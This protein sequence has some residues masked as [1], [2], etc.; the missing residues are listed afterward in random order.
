MSRKH[1]PLKVITRIST[2][3]IRRFLAKTK[4]Q[5]IWLL[6]TIFRTQ[7]KQET[8]NAGFVLPTV[9]MVSIVVVLLTTAIMLRSFDRA[10][11]ASNVRVSQGAITSATPAIDRGRAKI[12]L[13]F[14]D[15]TLPRA[16]PT[17]SSLYNALANSIEKYTFG[18]ETALQISFDING[19]GTI[20]TPTASTS[21]YNNE[22]MKTAWKFPVDTD[23]NG[24]FDSYNIYGI[25]F[26]TPPV[27]GT[28]QYKQARNVLEA[29]TPPMA[30]GTVDANCDANSSA[31]LVGNSGWVKQSNKLK[32]SFFVY[33]ATVPIT[34]TST[35]TNYEIYKGNKGFAAV[36]YQQDRVQIPPNNTAVVYED[37]IALSPGANFNLNGSVFTNSNFITSSVNGGAIR[38]YQVS[39]T[40]SCYYDSKNAKIIVGGNTALGGFLS[41]TNT[42]SATVDL[43]NGKATAVGTG[44]WIQS[45]GSSPS[46]IA[47]NN[48]AYVNRI[49]K[50][51]NAQVAADS[52]GA[53][54]PIE[55]KNGLIAKQQSLGI[56][57]T[58]PSADF[59]KYRRQQL[60]FY[61]RKRTRRVPYTEV[62]FSSTDTDPTPLL[63]GS[64]DTLRPNDRWTYPTSPT[65]GK[66]D[67]TY[68]KV[69]LNIS[70][71]SLRPVAT[72]PT[73]LKNNSGIE[74][75]I[76]DRVLVGNNLPQ[77]WWD[78]SKSAFVGPNPT[79]TQ[80]I[81]GIRW[82][83]GD[84][85][86]TRTR[87]S[88]VQTL[89]DVGSIDRDGEWELAAA[90]VPADITEPVGGLRVVTGAGI[91]LNETGTPASFNNTI[92]TIW[93]DT[94]PVPQAGIQAP[95]SN[96]PILPSYSS[97]AKTIKPYSNYGDPF[98]NITYKWREIPN[99][100]TPFLQMRATAVYHYKSTSYNAQTPTPIA[101]VS[102]FHVPTNST[103]AK[104]KSTLPTASG[105]SSDTNG[106]SDNGIVYPAPNAG[107]VPD[108]STVLTYQSQL[109]YPNGR[110]I[111]DGLLARALAKTAANRTISEQSAIDAQICALRIRYDSTFTP[112]TTNPV[113]DHGAIRE[114][115]L[116]DAREVK[117]NSGGSGTSATSDDVILPTTTYDLPV[118]DR[119][120]VEIR[121]TV[122]DLN[123]LRTKTIGSSSPSQEYLLPNSGI[124]YA[125]RDDALRDMSADIT[126]FP[127]TSSNNIPTEANKSVS[128]VDYK[129]DPSRRPN[130]IM[131]VNGSKLWRGLR[132]ATTPPDY[133]N[134][135]KGLILAT[136]L[137][138]YLKGDFN[139]HTQ[140]EF[141]TALDSDYGNFY[142]R[143]T[144]NNNFACRTGDPRLSSC[145]TGDEWRPATVLA[146]A[147]TLL[148]S[149][150]REGLRNEGDY[151][152]N[153]SLDVST[154]PPGLV[155]SKYNSYAPSNTSWA[156]TTASN[157]GFPKDFDTSTDDYQGSSYVNNFVT[158]LIRWL[159]ARTASQSARSVPSLAFAYEVCTSST[160]SECF[161]SSTDTA[162]QCAVKN[163]RWALTNVALSGYNGTNGQN[164]WLDGDINSSIN[165]IKTGFIGPNGGSNGWQALPFRRIAVKLERY[166]AS[167]YYTLPVTPLT[168]YGD[169]GGNGAKL[170]EYP[171][172]GS[173]APSIVTV[174]TKAAIP[175]FIEVSGK[176]EPVLQIRYPYGTAS[177]PT[178]GGSVGG[179]SGDWVQPALN[180][181]TTF[182]LIVAAGDS[183]ARSSSAGNEDNGGLHNFVRFAQIW[184]GLTDKMT[185]SFMQLRKSAYATGPFATALSTSDSNL[186]YAINL[187]NGQATGYLP[188]TR[189]WGY[190]V[191]LLSQSPDLFASKLVI[192]PPDLP[193]EYLREVG[194][195]DKWVQ[196]LLC[197]KTTDTTP[198]YAID[199]DQRPST[200][201][202]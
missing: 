137:P 115:T 10:K 3:F 174:T 188:P 186:L 145:N 57:L 175:W 168:Y 95:P 196:Q 51:I 101:C 146:D 189:Q 88:L 199:T 118:K 15:P 124:I 5:I 89:A 48:L 110:S 164:I 119:Q 111:D 200:C 193:D 202:S 34:T 67:T 18:D 93:P 64:V 13:L 59:T 153:N 108:Y 140:E 33:T 102:S 60:E 53:N 58:N 169:P 135:E 130:A 54:D 184:S 83:A 55:V 123:L 152:W 151:D 99:A 120:P 92:P 127:L 197:A 80:N 173:D 85:T 69:A 50:L 46:A 104:N 121:V 49:N 25:Y 42:G 139:L 73:F 190:D 17:D 39:S 45:A 148:T 12:N 138:V 38:F 172:G 171:V 86:K 160:N 141:T 149:N 179:T 107:T 103:T 90:K 23:N 9:A 117:Q 191:A 96:S 187:N 106:L 87:Q 156:D 194:R 201:Q 167:P 163:R 78:T 165:A 37:D 32:K 98:N 1:Q 56:T 62:A 81:T 105:I 82:N 180:D 176:L 150:Y 40:S 159:P 84:T 70:G 129:L 72:E 8:A 20:E 126:A 178:G 77:F 4:K 122:L 94:Y 19:N 61:F 162:A 44:A 14:N 74:G 183:P 100:N 114:I 195:D 63:Q 170:T 181:I 198:A 6:R 143:T 166:C 182:N 2:R 133:R 128:P 47:Y 116:L 142:D 91:Y 161:C 158:P 30:V 144:I 28:G 125:T 29:R 113:I 11:N 36:E 41:T 134:E 192:T 177:N 71:T 26:R 68:A 155:L 66:T 79:D 31:S 185:G 43:Y 35:D 52:T 109:T 131:L 97:S 21:I 147:A 65:D 112:V 7:N 22:T 132:T 24:K 157:L 76:G 16:T 27:T 136:N 75:Q 154:V